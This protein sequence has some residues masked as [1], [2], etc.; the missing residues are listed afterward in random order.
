VLLEDALCRQTNWEQRVVL[1]L[2][3]GNAGAL[4]VVSRTT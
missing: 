2:R 4:M 1:V 3:T